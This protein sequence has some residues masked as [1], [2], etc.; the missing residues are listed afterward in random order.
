MHHDKFN[1]T[2]PCHIVI[3]C[4]GFCYELVRVR[5]IYL[6]SPNYYIKYVIILILNYECTIWNEAFFFKN[7]FV[8]SG[9]TNS[10]FTLAQIYLKWPHS[11]IVCNISLEKETSIIE[12]VLWTNK[13][14]SPRDEDQPMQYSLSWNDLGVWCSWI[15][16]AE[17]LSCQCS[18]MWR[19][20]RIPANTGLKTKL[21]LNVD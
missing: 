16:C 1:M 19:K 9:F 5:K 18:L 15:L 11:I 14:I 10:A 6:F 2:L 12:A 17:Q 8:I 21:E 13:Q 3:W 20:M 7:H 4:Q